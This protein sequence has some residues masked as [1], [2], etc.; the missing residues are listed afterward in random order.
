MTWAEAQKGISDKNAEIERLKAI[1]T[2]LADLSESYL[3]QGT[4]NLVGPQRLWRGVFWRNSRE[5]SLAIQRA[6]E[7]TR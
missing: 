2:E 3:P 4:D 6:R 5:L 1:I 7:A